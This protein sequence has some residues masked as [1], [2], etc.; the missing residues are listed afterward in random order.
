MKIPSQ[1]PESIQYAWA[2]AE[3]LRRLDFAHDEISFETRTT[4]DQETCLFTTAT[5]ADKRLLVCAGTFSPYDPKQLHELMRTWIVSLIDLS[6]SSEDLDNIYL[7]RFVEAPFG[8]NELIG[9]L[10]IAGFKLPED[11]ESQWN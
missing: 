9:A 5:R 2:Y 6:F 8:P 7:K 10:I 1:F 4:P 11:K 3:A